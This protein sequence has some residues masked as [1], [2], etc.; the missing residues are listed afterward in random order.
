MRVPG[1]Q[2]REFQMMSSTGPRPRPPYCTGRWS[3]AQPGSCSV[4]CRCLAAARRK[5]RALGAESAEEWTSIAALARIQASRLE[6]L[7]GLN[8]L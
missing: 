3:A 6:R 5:A 2:C 8:D 7:R 4:R 1:L